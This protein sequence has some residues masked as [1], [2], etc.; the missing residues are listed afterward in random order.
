MVHVE[1][2]EGGCPKIDV[3][4]YGVYVCVLLSVVAAAFAVVVVVVAAAGLVVPSYA[5][6]A[7]YD[8]AVH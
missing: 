2:Q 7:V 5:V 4:Q 1:V 6:Y 8:A 3:E